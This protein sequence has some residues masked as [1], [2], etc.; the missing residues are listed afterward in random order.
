M[1][2]EC[3]C[4][5][6]YGEKK[7]WGCRWWSRWIANIEIA[8]KNKAKLEVYYFASAVS[9]GKAQNF[10]TVGEENLRREQISKRRRKFRKSRNFR[11]AVR[12]GLRNLSEKSEGDGSSPYCREVNRLFLE[13]LPR[14]DCEFV[15]AAEGL[16]TSQKAEVAWLERKGCNYPAK[17]VS[18]WVAKEL[19]EIDNCFTCGAP[20]SNLSPRLRPP[21]G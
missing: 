3:W 4:V 2:G 10:E 20:A 18:E 14:D 5:P 7:E 6:L 21:F 12:T 16:G 8:V 11:D 9:K 1:Y 13:W 17:D 19:R 15:V